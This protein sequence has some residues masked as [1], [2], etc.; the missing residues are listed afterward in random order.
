MHA[1]FAL[2]ARVFTAQCRLDA[3]VLLY[4]SALLF[5]K[6]SCYRAVFNLTHNRLWAQECEILVGNSAVKCNSDC[7]SNMK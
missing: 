4:S 5:T 3:A 1:V 6:K 2:C 7:A